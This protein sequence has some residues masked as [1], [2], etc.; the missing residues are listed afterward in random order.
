MDLF[1]R[2]G[3]IALA[4]SVFD[5]LESPN[6]IQYC[7]LI[8]AFGVHGQP[9]RAEFLVQQMLRDD[10]KV[11][12]NIS[13][14]NTL[15]NAW[16]INPSIPDAPNRAL[17]IIRFMDHDL[18]CIQLGLQPDV[19]SFNTVL[20]CLAATTSETNLRVTHETVSLTTTDYSNPDEVG[21]FAEK[22]L[23]EMV[24][25]FRNGN[26]TVLPDVISYNSCIQACANV[27]DVSRIEPLL[28]RMKQAGVS[29]NLR[30]YNNILLLYAQFGTLVAAFKAEQL[31][32]ELKELSKTNASLAP[33]VYSYNLVFKA[34]GK[35]GDPS[36]QHQIWATFQVMRQVD[37]I[38][39]DLIMCTFLI[40]HWSKLA[41]REHL[42]HATALLEEME[43]NHSLNLQLRPDD[44]HYMAV[45]EGW[46]N[47][48]IRTATNF[49]LRFVL[50]YTRG[51]T[52]NGPPTQQAMHQIVKGWIKNGDLKEAMKFIDKM[53]S[54]SAQPKK[55]GY[56]TLPDGPGVECY[57]DLLTAWVTS[58][59]EAGHS[60]LRDQNIT[61]LRSKLKVLLNVAEGVNVV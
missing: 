40:L 30:T 54:F 37:G 31:L 35:S 17:A 42:E 56:K 49:F 52:G 6:V 16:A 4:Q 50:N 25:R 28:K 36:M 53:E 33:D 45:V 55:K 5:H 10:S 61:K 34:M 7:L 57:R 47:R 38:P 20:K 23:D 43:E 8:K 22:I 26:R 59:S 13:A 27:G 32:L 39:P 60:V 58:S 29:P 19:V 51:R 24:E 3:N 15:L 41:D 2:E 12:P 9:E 21:T 44:R 11:A 14:F 18:K 1:A 46:M 48:D